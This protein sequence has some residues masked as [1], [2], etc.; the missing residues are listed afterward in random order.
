IWIDGRIIKWN[1]EKNNWQRAIGLI[2][3]NWKY[4]EFSDRDSDNLKKGLFVALKRLNNSSNIKDQFLNEMTEFLFPIL[5]ITQDPGTSEYIIVMNYAHG[6]SLRSN[7]QKICRMNWKKR[8]FILNLIIFGLVGIHQLNLVHKDLH[9]G[10][11]LVCNYFNEND[12]WNIPLIS[13]LGLSQRVQK[14]SLKNDI[15]DIRD[16]KIEQAIM[17]FRSSDKELQ[18]ISVQPTAQNAGHT[19][20]AELLTYLN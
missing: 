10:N 11:I 9:S 16:D 13:D 4:K 17:Q 8:L 15:E 18:E 12:D 19:L 6:G 3:D 5:G 20:Q 14:Y 1:H 7:L 2:D